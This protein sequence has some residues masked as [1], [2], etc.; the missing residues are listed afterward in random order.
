MCMT[1][2]VCQA[3]PFL[4]HWSMGLNQLAKINFIPLESFIFAEEVCIEQKEVSCSDDLL[5]FRRLL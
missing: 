5:T 3:V 2:D 4:G 1:L